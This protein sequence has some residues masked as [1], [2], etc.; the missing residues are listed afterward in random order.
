MQ[1]SDIIVGRQYAIRLTVS[2]GQPL[3]KVRVLEKLGRKRLVKVRHLADP[4]KGLEEYVQT[5][6]FVVPWG[7]QRSFLRDEERLRRL[8]AL[9]HKPG[10][11]TRRKAVEVVLDS[12]SY[13]STW[14][15]DGGWLEMEAGE[16]QQLADRAGLDRSPVDMH[17]DAYLDRMGE[18]HLPL[19]VAET[20]AR[21]FAT[22]EPETV[23]LMIHDDETEYEA[24]GYEPGERFWHDY[25][26]EHQPAFALA[27]Q[28]PGHEQEVAQLRKELERLQSLVSSAADSVER[29]GDE[30]EASRLRRALKGR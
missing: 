14:M 25:L 3:Y 29:A 28:W 30:R 11:T 9:P 22:A 17:P 16:L 6:Q 21:A 23:L 20:L 2:A 7:E 5:R 24:R 26:R 15:R 27:R 1:D 4:H 18:A 13:S 19:E 10:D 8:K 12:A